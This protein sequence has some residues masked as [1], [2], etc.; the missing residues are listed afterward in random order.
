MVKLSQKQKKVCDFMYSKGEVL[1]YVTSED[2]KF[3][4][5]AFC[6]VFGVQNVACHEKCEIFSNSVRK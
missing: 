1:D 3:I 5:L 4:K 2:V 6:D